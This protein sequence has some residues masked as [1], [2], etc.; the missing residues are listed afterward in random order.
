VGQW[1]QQFPQSSDD[2]VRALLQRAGRER[3]P[4]PH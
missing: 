3:V 4:E 1:Y 2:E